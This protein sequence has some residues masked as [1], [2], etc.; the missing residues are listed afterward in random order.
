MSRQAGREWYF[1]IADFDEALL[2]GTI[3]IKHTDG[4]QSVRIV[5]SPEAPHARTRTRTRR[6]Q[7]VLTL[8]A[9]RFI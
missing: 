2:N 5:T 1:S 9:M 6:V 4:A 3:E 8:M 7:S